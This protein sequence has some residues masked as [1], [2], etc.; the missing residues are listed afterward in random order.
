MAVTR[1]HFI[2]QCS[3]AGAIVAATL[4]DDALPRVLAAVRDARHRSPDD[5]AADEDFWTH[6]QLAYDVDRSLINLNN[7]GVAPAPRSV[8]DAMIRH[9]REVNQAPARRL[10]TDLDPQVERARADLAR[11][12]RCLPEEIAITRNTTESLHIVLLGLDLRP[13]DEVLTTDHDY[14]RML[15]ALRKRQLRE[16]IVLKTVPVPAPPEHPDQ[17]FEIITSAVTPRTRLILV[18]HIVFLTGQIF[19]V[20]RICRWA[21]HR[22]IDVV[23]D[24]AHSFAHLDFT[25]DDLDC[26]FFGT[27]LHKWLSAPIGT[28]MLYV[29]RD[30]IADVWPLMAG[31]DPRSSDIR[32]FEEIGTHPNAPRLAIADALLFHH[33]IGPAR[34]LARLRYLRDRWAGALAPHPRVRLRTL[35][36]PDQAGA[37]ATMEIIG[38]TGQQLA[39]YLWK[40]HRI[41]VTPIRFEPSAAHHSSNHKT[42]ANRAQQ[43][44]NPPPAIRAARH[45][46]PASTTPDDFDPYRIDGIR[47]TP[48]VYTT[49]AEIDTFV[50]AIRHVLDKGLPSA[51]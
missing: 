4:R 18:S 2:R 25:R 44:H 3:V 22:G 5:L 40:R 33:T 41:I 34:K 6:I 48:N 19:P 15:N 31:P 30:R 46:R 20:G 23:V 13:G 42:R 8:F 36:D 9:L 1:R 21:R 50:E 26:D 37:L 12:F 7:G 49:L 51:P 28:G 27:S 16:N 39:D 35:L 10:W 47:V 43:T 14:P 11:T 32:K 45:D 29:R 17:L 24:G 38:I